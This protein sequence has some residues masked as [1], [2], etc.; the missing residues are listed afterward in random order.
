M[1]LAIGSVVPWVGAP[2]SRRN[3]GF[4]FGPPQLAAYFMALRLNGA[5]RGLTVNAVRAHAQGG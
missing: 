2:G 1:S 3:R 5:L 4:C